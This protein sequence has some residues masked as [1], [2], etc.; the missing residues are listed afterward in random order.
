MRFLVVVLALL[1][2][3]GCQIGAGPTFGYRRGRA[4]IGWEAGPGVMNSVSR[5]QITRVDIGQSYRAGKSFSY[6]TL[7]GERAVENSGRGLS[8]ASFSLGA[9]GGS[10]G[11]GSVVLGGAAFAAGLEERD[12]ASDCGG[13]YWVGTLSAGVRFIAGE[14]ELYV[15]PRIDALS[16][17][18]F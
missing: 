3:A 17:P 7:T 9:G 2:L 12:S 4:T 8:G 1:T 14:P 16:M 13:S 6:L 5:G 18:C 11:G 15:A 10:D